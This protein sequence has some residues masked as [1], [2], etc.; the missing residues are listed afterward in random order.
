M[1][2]FVTSFYFIFFV[3][4]LPVAGYV[5]NKVLNS[6]LKF[7]KTTQNVSSFIKKISFQNNTM[8]SSVALLMPFHN[9]EPINNV[10]D[11]SLD[12]FVFFFSNVTF[13]YVFSFVLVFFFLGFIVS[14]KSQYVISLNRISAL[15]ILYIFLILNLSIVNRGFDI[16]V[17]NIP[18]GINL[19]DFAFFGYFL[20]L[21]KTQSL[22]FKVFI[23]YVFLMLFIFLYG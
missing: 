6:V 14:N 3:V 5:E 20:K 7:R 19:D 10:I 9:I 12:F 13:F 2:N 23:F 8:K 1:A 15:Y 22:F 21:V 11:S 4:I 17:F 18:T 16:S